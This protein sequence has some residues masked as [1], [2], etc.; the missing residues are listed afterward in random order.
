MRYD[1][2]QW[3]RTRLVGGDSSAWPKSGSSEIVVGHLGRERFLATIEPWHGNSV[4][5]YRQVAGAWTRHVID[6]SITDGHTMVVGDV[7]GDGQ[8]EIV[9]GERGG[10]RSVY[11]Y[12]SVDVQQDAWTKQTID[13]GRM[14]AAGCAV[15]D[16][17]GDNR[18]DVVC[19]GT[20]T[21]NLK[22][23][24]NRPSP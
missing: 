16:L 9:V 24:E 21:A 20:A 14:A 8:D 6:G 2:G 13:D 1:K 22:W 15:A 4:V 11:L 17:N 19:I 7:D 3:N 5:V 12:R 23:Y 18:L 10:R